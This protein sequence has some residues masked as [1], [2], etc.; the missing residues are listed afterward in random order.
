MLKRHTEH[1]EYN[2]FADADALYCPSAMHHW[3]V[4]LELCRQVTF[5]PA[6][7]PILEDSFWQTYWEASIS[8]FPEDERMAITIPLLR[9]LL[10]SP[11][12]SIERVNLSVHTEGDA[13]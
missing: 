3:I 11:P 4:D 7:M 9:W 2:A 8:P 10:S 6:D 13:R 5:G 1:A 12:N